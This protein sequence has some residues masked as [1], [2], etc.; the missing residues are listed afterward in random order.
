MSPHEPR[1]R[2]S[3]LVTGLLVVTVTV[4][5]LLAAVTGLQG[6]IIVLRNVLLGLLYV[7]WPVAVI[8]LALRSFFAFNT[9]RS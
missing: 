1:N 9:W 7:V 5:G 2:A 4:V 8:D 6:T 3:A